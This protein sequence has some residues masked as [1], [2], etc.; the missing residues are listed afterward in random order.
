MNELTEHHAPESAGEASSAT[1][2][3][4]RRIYD[5]STSEATRE[6]R[7]TS[8]RR[9]DAEEKL[10]QHLIEARDRVPHRHDRDLFNGDPDIKDPGVGSFGAQ[11]PEPHEEDPEGAAR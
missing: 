3:K 11:R 6:L 10:Q 5:K 7:N 8:R 2:L 4:S 9:R 1:E